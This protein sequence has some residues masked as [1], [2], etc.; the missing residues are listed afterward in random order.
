MTETKRYYLPHGLRMT[1]PR[2]AILD[3]VRHVCGHPN[4]EEVFKQVRRRLPHVSLATVYRNLELL[5][6]AGL[7]RQLGPGAEQMRFDANVEQH[8]HVRCTGCGR[9]ADLKANGRM[10]NERS[11]GR[12]TDFLV[13][14]HR[15]E[16]VGLCPDC[17]RRG[18]RS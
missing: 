15:L 10:V 12:L 16:F 5:S 17:R 8:Y 7:L 9:V 6:G 2:Q 13:T 14:G 18:N 4:A 3:V 11:V 1:A